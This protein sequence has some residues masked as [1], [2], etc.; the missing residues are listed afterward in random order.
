MAESPQDCELSNYSF[1]VIALNDPPLFQYL[2]C[3]SL[4]CR[5]VHRFLD[6]TK[7]ALAD[8]ALEL[9]ITDSLAHSNLL[10]LII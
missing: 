8:G 2:N 4:S 3:D 6:E 7:G 9:E 5:C 1:D 10:F